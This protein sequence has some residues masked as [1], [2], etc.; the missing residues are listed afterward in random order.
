MIL[1]LPERKNV[2]NITTSLKLEC[3]IFIYIERS[4]KSTHE[5]LALSDLSIFLSPLECMRCCFDL[6]L[7]MIVIEWNHFVRNVACRDFIDMRGL[8]VPNQL[9]R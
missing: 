1:L 7:G 2:Q 8:V 9:K 5:N 4:A 3:N 6:R